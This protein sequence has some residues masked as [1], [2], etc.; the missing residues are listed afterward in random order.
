MYWLTLA[1]W[2]YLFEGR[3]TWRKVWCRATGH[4]GVWFYNVGGLEP[5]MSCR[6]CDDNLG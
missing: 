3:W 2:Q 6:G 4:R 1:W 5:D